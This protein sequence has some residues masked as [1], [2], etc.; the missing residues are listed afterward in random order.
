MAA[1]VASNSAVRYF[2][3]EVKKFH[4]R[5]VKKL[6]FQFDP[7]HENAKTVRD[8]YF[9]ISSKK[10]RKTNQ[11]CVFKADVVN[12]RSEPTIS[13]DL[14]NGL[15]VLFKCSNLST[16]EVAKEFN[17]IIEKYDVKEEDTTIKLKGA[18][19]KETK[20]KKRK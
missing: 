3:A 11:S 14:S 16:L 10:I 19:Q 17:Q 7:F 1:R 2:Y 6:S 15:N 13:V 4:L 20:A 5:P 12:D 9:H 8:F 18:L